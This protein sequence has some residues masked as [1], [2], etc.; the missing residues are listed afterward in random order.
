MSPRTG[1][2][3]GSLLR[4]GLFAALLAPAGLV[5]AD[6]GLDRVAG[7][8][9]FERIWVPAPAST[10]GAD[11]LG[12]MF[13]ERSCSGCHGGPG[14]GA[15]VAF[16]PE[17]LAVRGLTIRLGDDRGRP[18]PLYGEAFQANAVQ[19]LP[20]EGTLRFR[21]RDRSAPVEA[22]A[23]PGRGPFSA[24]TRLSLRLTPPLV[25]RARIEAADEAAIL[26]AADPDDGDGDGI[27]G[28]PSLLRTPDGPRLG[29]FGWKAER[30]DLEAQVAHAFAIDLGLS[31]PLAP[32]PH[33]DCT[34]AEP[35]CRA[36]PDGRSP[37]F[38]GEEISG[39]M[40]RL[41]AGYVRG[42]EPPAGKEEDAAGARLFAATGCAACHVPR[43]PSKAGGEVTLYS[44]LLLHDLGPALDDGVGAEGATSSEWRT[45]P[46]AGLA[47]SGGSAR[48]YLHDGRAPT[49]DAAI[50]AHGGEA[51][52]AAGRYRALTSAERSRLIAFLE[53]L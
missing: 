10:D 33:G 1:P 49:L 23:T 42:L 11:G 2:G 12:P 14:L 29:R 18:D 47:W 39:T 28:R 41:V 34:E 26:A 48:R 40:I 38:D 5:L 30:A 37:A 50:R 8:A 24:G 32:L 16:T 21:A 52:D 6:A 9:L 20:P 3:R 13:T 36:L 51:A 27:S 19:G 7:K 43:L 53:S 44:D 15:T 46:L 4:L 22:I 31:S 25:A 35:D 45:P 17:G